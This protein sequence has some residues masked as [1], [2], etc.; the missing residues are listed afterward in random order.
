MLR[1]ISWQW[2][3]QATE[4]QKTTSLQKAA[5]LPCTHGRNT[6]ECRDSAVQYCKILQNIYKNGVRISTKCWIHKRHAII[7]GFFCECL[8]EIGRIITALQC[9]WFLAWVSWR[10]MAELIHRGY[11]KTEHDCAVVCSEVRGWVYGGDVC[12]GSPM[13]QP[14]TA[15]LC[16]D[17][18]KN[19]MI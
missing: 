7:W 9:M 4:L 13:L 3:M 17:A 8:M 15:L 19:Q 10:E 16:L 2:Q 14:E 6:V 12:G 1:I 18:C 5:H 11:P